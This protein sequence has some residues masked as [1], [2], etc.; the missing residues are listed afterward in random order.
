MIRQTDVDF[1]EHFGVSG[2]KWGV[3]RAKTDAPATPIT[4]HQQQAKNER[5]KMLKRSAIVAGVGVTVAVG[6]F[7]A[8]KHV[9]LS[10]L[11]P[12]TV[13]SG[14]NETTKIL[15]RS[16]DTKISA[17]REAQ[18][19]AIELHNAKQ[20][21]RDPEFARM[22]PQKLLAKHEIAKAEFDSYLTK[23]ERNQGYIY[24][25]PK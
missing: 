15:S 17:V 12:S 25:G 5:N 24:R 2:M 19:K 3:R 22:T 10:R 13:S 11:A 23:L 20:L 1:L 21:F 9:P 4:P 18:K 6:L 7:V 8:N 16:K 14:K